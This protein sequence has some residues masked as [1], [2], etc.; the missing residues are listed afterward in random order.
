MQVIVHFSLYR[1]KHARRGS[2]PNLQNKVPEEYFVVS[3]DELLRV[4]Y[5]LLYRRDKKK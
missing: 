5:L 4:K 3:N 1:S 2:E